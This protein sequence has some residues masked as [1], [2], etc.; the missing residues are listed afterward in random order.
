M[1]KNILTNVLFGLSEVP[2]EQFMQSS[3]A[4]SEIGFFHNESCS[5]FT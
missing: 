3:N 4:F 5:E 2:V 1:L